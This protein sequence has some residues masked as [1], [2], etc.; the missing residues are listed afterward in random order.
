MSN[1]KRQR[2]AIWQAYPDCTFWTDKIII[3]GFQERTNRFLSTKNGEGP[4][5]KPLTHQACPNICQVANVP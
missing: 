2:A 4:N 1:R 3:R 5:K